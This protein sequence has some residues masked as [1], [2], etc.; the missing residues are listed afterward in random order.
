MVLIIGLTVSCGWFAVGNPA[1]TVHGWCS[2]LTAAA[3]VEAS[4]VVLVGVVVGREEYKREEECDEDDGYDYYD[5]GDPSSPAVP[6]GR[7]AEFIAAVEHVS[8]CGLD[9]VS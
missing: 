6:G 5:E 3:V 9:T 7:A 8:L 1:G 2:A 4:V